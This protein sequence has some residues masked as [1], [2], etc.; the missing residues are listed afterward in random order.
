MPYIYSVA[1]PGSALVRQERATLIG[2]SE[3]DLGAC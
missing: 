2:L 1:L 3:M